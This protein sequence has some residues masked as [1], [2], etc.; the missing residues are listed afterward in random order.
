MDSSGSVGL[1][2]EKKISENIIKKLNYL[3]ILFL[4]LD[5]YKIEYVVIFHI[6]DIFWVR[7]ACQH[8]LAPKSAKI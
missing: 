4:V 3:I 7:G 5:I 2:S 8:P 6:F 1:N